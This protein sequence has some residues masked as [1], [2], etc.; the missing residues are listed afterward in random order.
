MCCAQQQKPCSA[1]AN[2]SALHR[3]MS[4]RMLLLSLQSLCTCRWFSGA[5]L[6]GTLLEVSGCNRTTGDTALSVYSTPSA[7][8]APLDWYCEG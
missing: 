3:S 6:P 1:G 8:P 7:T 5:V 2:R 4:M